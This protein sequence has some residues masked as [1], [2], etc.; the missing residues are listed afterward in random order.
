MDKDF[1]III[2]GVGGQGIITLIKIIDQAGFFDGYDVRS[3][4]LHGLAQRGGS[5]TAHIR[6]GKKINSPLVGLKSADLVIS[7][8]LTE[9]L[10][11]LDYASNNTNIVIND[12]IISFLNGPSKEKIMEKLPKKNVYMLP[13]SDHTSYMLGFLVKNKLIPISKESIIKAMNLFIKNKYI[14][15]NIQSFNLAYDK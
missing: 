14:D 12:K 7:T 15:I 1:N 9:T 3:S 8:E 5:V 2:S 6:L 4:E 13:A 10:R 11:V